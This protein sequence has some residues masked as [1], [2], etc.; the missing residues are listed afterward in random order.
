MSSIIF[1]GT[2]GGNAVSKQIQSAGGIILQIG[3]LQFHLDPGP[4]A[5]SKAKEYGINLNRNTVVLVSHNH[6]NHCSE[7]NPILDAM[8]HSGIDHRGMVLASKSVILGHEEMAPALTKHH[9]TMPE[10]VIP[11]EKNHKVGIELVE[12]HAL[13]AEHT[14]PT[15]LGFKFLCPSFTLSYT[16]D[17]NIT[18]QL[19]Q[20]LAGTDILILNVPF[21]GNKAA[22][23]NLDTKAA[24]KAVAFVKP[25]VAILT[26]F[27]L[28]MFKAGIIEEAREVQR[29]TE[30]PTIAAKD[31]LLVYPESYLH[32][33]PVKGF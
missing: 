27:G 3:E 29:M 31:G 14:D 15:A 12:I 8:T 26:H 20:D 21:P 28:E 16:G 11:M 33:N 7:L 25:K 19:L 6:I 1:L 24:V 17:T 30:V 5:L 9:I 32:K 2:A 22:G 10:K 13:M 18:P 4:G 23:M